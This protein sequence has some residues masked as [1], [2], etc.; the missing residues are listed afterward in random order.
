MKIFL[1]IFIATLAPGESI[2]YTKKNVDITG[3]IRD[4]DE[5][6]NEIIQNPLD[7]MPMV[8]NDAYIVHSTSWRYESDGSLVLTYMVYSEHVIFIGD[9][10]RLLHI[11]DVRMPLSRDSR[12]P[13]PHRIE[14][15]HVVL[16]GIRHLSFLL[17]TVSD[18]L[19]ADSLSPKSRSFFGTMAAALGGKIT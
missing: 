6:V 18:G 16:H 17:L 12:R 9:N 3:N 2:A 5:I 7:E 15:E 14:E 11:R 10:H 1:E 8:R 19:S 13:R 4:P